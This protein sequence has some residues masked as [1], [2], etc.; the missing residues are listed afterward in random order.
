MKVYITGHFRGE[1]SQTKIEGLSSAVQAAGMKDF[2]FVRDVEKYHQHTFDNPKDRWLR[3]NDEIAACDS[4]FVDIADRSNGSRAVECGIA[5]ALGKPIIVAVKHG[6]Q[7]KALFDDISSTVIEYQSYKDITQELKAYDKE[8]NFNITDKTMLFMVLALFGMG[9]A[10]GLAQAF[11]PLALAWAVVYWLIVR[12]IFASMRI[13]DRIIIYVPLAVVW[14]GGMVLMYP[15]SA[16][17][18]L[19]WTIV[20]WFGA[21]LILQRLKLAL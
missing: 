6:T 16:P 1:A 3:I 21:L 18:A 8:R 17:L 9:S 19:A 10:W 12:R 4:M 14:I 7:Y 20:F 13:F 11:I 2:C 15:I 5:Y